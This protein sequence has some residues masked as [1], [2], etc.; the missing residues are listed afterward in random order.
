MKQKK[1]IHQGTLAP[2]VMKTLDMLGPLHGYG[3]AR[4]I[5]QI[6]DLPPRL[7]QEGTIASERGAPENNRRPRFYGPDQTAAIVAHFF[8]V[9][10][11]DLE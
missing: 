4:R 9:K 7:E 11:G 5:E 6:G 10:A 8:E 3:I 1:D 2:I